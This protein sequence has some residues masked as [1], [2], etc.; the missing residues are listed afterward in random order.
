MKLSHYQAAGFYAIGLVAPDAIIELPVA[1]A[2]TIE[3]GDY[4]INNAAGYATQTATDTS[5]VF[6][7]IAAEDCNNSA[8]AA[9]AKIVKV[10]RAA[11][12]N[13]IRFSVPVGNL[14]V[15]ARANVGTLC[16]LNTNALLDIADAACATGTVGFWIEDFDASAEAIDGNTLGYAIGSFRIA[17]P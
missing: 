17:A 10:I 16:D 15:I 14:A 4:I 5:L 2:I 11:E 12:C 8:G 6:H 1:A 7:G 9:G 13:S 3:K